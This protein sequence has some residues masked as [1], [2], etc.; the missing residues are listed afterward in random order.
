MQPALFC[1]YHPTAILN[2][3]LIMKHTPLGSSQWYKPCQLKQLA[4]GSTDE[5]EDRVCLSVNDGKVS[6]IRT[7][8]P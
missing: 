4:F 8:R 3:A 1:Q 7:R 6:V 5:L 2:H